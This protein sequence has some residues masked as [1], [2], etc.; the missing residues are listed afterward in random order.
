MDEEK[1]E[2][3]EEDSF[4]ENAGFTEQHRQ[5]QQRPHINHK[6]QDQVFE[7]LSPSSP[8]DTL[9]QIFSDRLHPRLLTEIGGGGGGGRASVD[10]GSVG[11]R[12]KPSN[13]TIAFSE[14]PNIRISA[15][16]STHSVNSEKSQIKEQ[17][18]LGKHWKMEQSPC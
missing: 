7:P 5:Q 8:N 14:I 15:A 9:E 11:I 12:N 2:E 6:D 13:N 17:I 1:E 3:D 16:S 18:K 4:R 10:M